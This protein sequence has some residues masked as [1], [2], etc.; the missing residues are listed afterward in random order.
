METG[1]GAGS[2]VSRS[3]PKRSG[4]GAGAAG[5][6]AD[7]LLSLSLSLSL[8]LMA[9]LGPEDFLRSRLGYDIVP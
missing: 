1:A 2:V 9:S 4:T 3:P 8:I 7:E 6:S 5:V